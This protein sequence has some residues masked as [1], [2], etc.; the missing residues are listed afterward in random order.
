MMLEDLVRTIL[1]EAARSADPDVVNMQLIEAAW[2]TLVGPDLARR[3]RPRR[4]SDG[5][6]HIE[7]SSTPWLQEFSY[8]R[9]DLTR[10]IQ[11]LF[12]WR[13]DEI[14]LS[15]AE[16]FVPVTASD[17]PLILSPRRKRAAPP[18]PRL[19]AEQERDA[20][21][22]L[23]KLDDDMRDIMQRLRRRIHED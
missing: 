5:T 23:D 14:H 10:R 12:P 16:R 20:K 4:W 7:V 17:D 21:A 13:L 2:P 1:R 19:D 6:L 22:D 15:V 8:R 9:D 18:G 3:T 11:R